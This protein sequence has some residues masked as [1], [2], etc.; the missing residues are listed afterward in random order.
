MTEVG[1]EEKKRKMANTQRHIYTFIPLTLDR[2]VKRMRTR[3]E[4]RQAKEYCSA[5]G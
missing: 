4:Y 2:K 3:V 1:G 5:R